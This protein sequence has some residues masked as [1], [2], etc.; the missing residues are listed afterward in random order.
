MCK[1]RRL[2]LIV[3]FLVVLIEFILRYCFGFCDALL[4]QES[5]SYEYIAQPNQDRCRFGAIIHYNSFSQRCEEPDSTKTKIL[6]LG[7]SVIFGGTWM[8]QD[9]L[10]TTLFTND[11][12]VQMLNISA[13]SWGPDNC[14][15]YI[16]ENGVFDSKA[17]ILVCS[18]HDAY[19]TMSFKNVVGESPNYPKEQYISA[20][21]ELL[22]RYLCPRVCVYVKKNGVILDPDEEVVMHMGNNRVAKKTN[23]FN[24]GF[25]EIKTIADSLY[26]P[27]V[28]YLHA[29]LGE[30]KRGEYNEMGKSIIKWASDNNVIL[31]SGLEEGENSSMY[32]DVIHYNEK[33]QVF[34]AK[35]FKKYIVEEGKIDYKLSGK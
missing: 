27:F 16:K 23:K 19:D 17:I 14:A 5:S 32:E 35:I 3:L 1:L 4:Y 29:E 18:S 30:L 13:G 25:E 31:V 26:I 15:A 20:I 24:P 11:T 10:A 2:L 12:G 34:L 6:G 22:D 8:D 9:S 7:D 28:I 33:G 21:V